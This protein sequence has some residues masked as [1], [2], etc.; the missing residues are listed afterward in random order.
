[1]TP[2]TEN[3]LNYLQVIIDSKN[4]KNVVGKAQFDQSS[5][6]YNDKWV[7]L[8]DSVSY[9]D[10]LPVKPDSTKNNKKEKETPIAMIIIVA[11]LGGLGLGA[12]ITFRIK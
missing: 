5:S 8:D 12:L 7:T 10:K 6:L 11:G 3:Q 2:F 4:P 1:M 9:S